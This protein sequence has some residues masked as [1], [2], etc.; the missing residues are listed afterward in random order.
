MILANRAI[1]DI[2]SMHKALKVQ[3]LIIVAY[4]TAKRFQFSRR[5]ISNE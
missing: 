3:D 5:F 2:V 1:P 4:T